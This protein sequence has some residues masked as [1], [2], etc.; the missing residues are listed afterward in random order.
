VE[1]AGWLVHLLLCNGRLISELMITEGNK[2]KGRTFDP[3]FS[4]IELNIDLVF[5][6]PSEL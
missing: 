3:A 6:H 4:L 5:K 2:Q 1:N